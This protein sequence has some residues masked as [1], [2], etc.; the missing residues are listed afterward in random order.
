MKHTKFAD[1]GLL[2]LCNFIWG[3][4][5]VVYKIVQRQTGPIFAVFLPMGIAALVLAFFVHRQKRQRDGPYKHL[6]LTRDD[7]YRFLLLGIV[8]QALAKPLTAF[9]VRLTLASDAALV[10]LTLP[11]ATA[12]MAY[13]ILGERM[14]K[15]R[16]LS[17]AI[18]IVGVV[19][20]SGVHLQGL[21]LTSNLFLIGNLMVFGAVMGSAFYNAYGKRLLLRYSPLEVLLY[22]DCAALLFLFPLVLIIEPQSFAGVLHFSLRVWLGIIFLSVFDYAISMVIF[23]TV[24][25]RLDA[26]QVGLSTYLMPFFGVLVAAV[27]LHEHLT[28]FAI[29]GGVLVLIST[30]LITIFDKP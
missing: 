8:G 10:I 26:I 29:V 14:T 2:L 25:S 23:L 24:L 12:V 11:I 7:I 27:V 1:W 15:L 17:F 5:F 3:S 6:G 20:T 16:W 18:A 19:E 9:G 13:I 21:N 30:V 4:Q 28:S 22:S